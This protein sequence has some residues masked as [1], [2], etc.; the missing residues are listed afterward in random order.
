[1]QPGRSAC[2]RPTHRNACVRVYCSA[3]AVLCPKLVHNAIIFAAVGSV[4][5]REQERPG[6]ASESLKRELSSCVNWMGVVLPFASAAQSSAGATAEIY[7]AI[8]KALDIYLLV[9]TLRVILTWFRNINWFNE[10]FATLRQFTDP[11]LNVFR[12]ILPAFGGI[13]VSP[14]IG[15]LLLNFVRNQLVHLSRTMIL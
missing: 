15:F 7:G 12:G 5:Q 10:P 4:W 8:A 11:F 3:N 2:L 14:M 9:L 1:M 13:D 6:K